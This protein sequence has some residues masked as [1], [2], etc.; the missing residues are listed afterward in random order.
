MKMKIIII[1]NVYLFL[2]QLNQTALSIVLT[3]ILKKKK[4]SEKKAFYIA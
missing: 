1:S 3:I 2:W 4:S